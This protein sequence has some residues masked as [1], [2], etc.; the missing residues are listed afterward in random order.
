[1]SSPGTRKRSIGEELFLVH[2][3]RQLSDDDGHTIL[4]KNRIRSVG[5]ELYEI[6]LKRAR[7]ME[8]DDEDIMPKPDIQSSKGHILRLRSRDVPPQSKAAKSTA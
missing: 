5:E 6:H 3:R 4:L 2:L 8:P 7:G 1:M